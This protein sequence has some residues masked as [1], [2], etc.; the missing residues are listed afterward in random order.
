M[1][2]NDKKLHPQSL[3]KGDIVDIIAPAGS[4][5]P[6]ILEKVTNYVK[7]LGL[8]PR[9][10]EGILGSDIPYH[11][12]TNEI[13][14]EQLIEALYSTDSKAIWC[15][16]GGYGSAKLVNKLEE[17]FDSKGLPE[18]PKLF[19]GFSDISNLHSFLSQKLG[20]QTLHAHVLTTLSNTAHDQMDVTLTKQVIFGEAEKFEL[21]LEAYNKVAL[22]NNTKITGEIVGGNLC[23][24][25]KTIGTKYQ[26]NTDDKIVILEDTNEAGYSVDRM[27]EHFQDSNILNKPVALIYGD[28]TY[29]DPTGEEQKI[30]TYALKD[31]ASDKDYP[32]Y[33]CTGIGHGQVN[34]PF[35]IGS[36]AEI[37][38]NF[39]GKA[40]ITFDYGF[41]QEI[42]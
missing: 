6:E 21:N 27:L 31:F 12:N 3:N 24:L 9:V 2:L 1:K 41:N 5:K 7:D 4:F 30:I 36:E 29:K 22:A 23:V 18:T 39:D 15:V 33:K 42:V 8:T 37:S 35:F 10:K 34:Y 38:E 32:V 16:R 26:I 13:R 28:F 25:D 17:T 11:S 19:I 14:A 40:S 20:W